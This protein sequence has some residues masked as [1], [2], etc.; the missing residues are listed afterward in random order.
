MRQFSIVL[1]SEAGLH[2]RPAGLLVQRASM[3]HSSVTV[4]TGGKSANAK[5]ILQLLGLGAKNGAEII[6]TV[7]GEDEQQCME[8][9]LELLSN[10]GE[11]NVK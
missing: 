2:A 4:E 8:S 6:F 10:A 11:N 3:F 5:S 1:Q 9:L 7:E